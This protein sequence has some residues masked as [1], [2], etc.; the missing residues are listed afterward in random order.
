MTFLIIKLLHNFS[1]SSL[2]YQKI[3][4]INKKQIN[5][6]NIIKIVTFKKMFVKN[7][8]SLLFV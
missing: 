8:F 6:Y 1:F 5:I 3:N 2:R 4:T 7:I